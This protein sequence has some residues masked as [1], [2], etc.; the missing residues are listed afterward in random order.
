MVKRR[1]TARV[2]EELYEELER[3]REYEQLDRTT[4]I[5][6]LLQRGIADW[7]LESA[8]NRYRDG[9]ISLGR[10]AE[11]A[12]STLWRF[13]D[14]L[15]DRGVELQYTEADLEADIGAGESVDADR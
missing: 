6:R 14:T 15:D 10:A 12:G 11:L 9:S 1:V 8:I 4:V 5:N 7:R 2:S 3:I 13:L